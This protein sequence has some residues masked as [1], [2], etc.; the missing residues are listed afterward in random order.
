MHI[1]IVDSSRVILRSVTESLL[2][3]GHTVESFTDSAKAKDYV[4]ERSDVTCVI[5][6]LEV[7]PIGGLELC[8]ALR[9]LAGARRPL[10]IIVMSSAHGSR[11]LGEVLDSGADDFMTKPPDRDELKARLRAAERM[12]KLQNEL[13]RQA[14]TDSMTRLLNRGAFLRITTEIVQ[15]L[16]DGG[17]MSALLIDIDHFKSINDRHGHSIGDEVI[18][19]VANVLRETGAVAC[20]FG[21]EEFVLLMPDHGPGGAGVIAHR[22]RT[23]CAGLRIKSERET[24]PF[25]VSIGI[26][27]WTGADTID[28]LL[29]RADI[30]LYAA[31]RDGRDRVAMSMSELVVETVS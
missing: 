28:G 7:H 11:S 24:I 6:S 14:D 17:V 4:K 18:R 22:I 2:S 1:A 26:S 3:S 31:K 5:T 16:G 21:G 8:W 25:T 15:N 12:V 29:K 23:R 10:S 13:I 19:G 20:R 9:S 30:A 27:T